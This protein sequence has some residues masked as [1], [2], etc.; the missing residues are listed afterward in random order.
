M[1]REGWRWRVN[2]ALVWV[3][4]TGAILYPTIPDEDGFP[5]SNYPMFSTP[6]GTTA[7]IYH[8]VGFTSDGR[9]YP[10]SPEMVGTDEIMQAYQTVKLAIRGGRA[11]SLCKDAADRVAS[12]REFAEV[13]R[14]QVRIDV[15][16]SVHYWEGDRSAS[17]TRVLAKCGVSR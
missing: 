14:L 4:L 6:K 11:G 5:L 15:F 9:G 16:E 8:V 13:T 7:K 1:A 17:K 10:L 3:G 2:A 12:S